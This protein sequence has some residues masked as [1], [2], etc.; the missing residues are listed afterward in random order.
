MNNNMHCGLLKII[1]MIDAKIYTPKA[2]KVG[3][4]V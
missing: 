2:L 1:F 4:I 3:M